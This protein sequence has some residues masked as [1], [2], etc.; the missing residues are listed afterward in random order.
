MVAGVV[1][2]V[3]VVVVVVGVV[4]AAVVVV[5]ELMKCIKTETAS[6]LQGP[7]MRWVHGLRLRL[8]LFAWSAIVINLV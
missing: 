7:C 8:S 2:L 4:A 3:V 5:E 1:V 6:K